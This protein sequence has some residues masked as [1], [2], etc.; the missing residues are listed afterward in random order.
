MLAATETEFT[1][2]QTLHTS[3]SCGSL[4]VFKIL[5]NMVILKK[6]TFIAVAIAICLNSTACIFVAAGMRE[7]QKAKQ[8]FDLSYEKALESV[9]MVLISL[10]LEFEEPVIRPD[11][12]V[13]KGKYN[14]EKNMYIEIF[15][16][17]SNESRIA[18]R[19][20]TSDAGKIDA[21]KILETIK[22]FANKKQQS[23]QN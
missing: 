8:N 10:N 21:Q 23:I 1:L 16:V 20:G 6:L 9:K 7:T 17:S 3:S 14:D 11:V 15:R 19:V 18:V 22:E 5:R 4:Y 13:V 12:T 2:K